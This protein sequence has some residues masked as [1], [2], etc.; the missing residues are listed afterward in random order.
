MEAGYLGVGNMGQPMGPQAAR[1]GHA[2]HADDPN[3]LSP[4][5]RG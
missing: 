1:R 2:L 5:D 4:L 3:L